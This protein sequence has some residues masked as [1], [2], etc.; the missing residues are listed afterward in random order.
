MIKT[1]LVNTGSNVVLMI[2]K[3]VVTLIMTPI[4]LSS[5]GSYD[6][7]LWGMI[8][9]IVGYMGL[10]DIGIRPS[11]SRFSA[12]YKA[13]NDTQNLNTV[14]VSTFLF[15]SVLGLF[16]C[17]CFVGWALIFPEVLSASD[18]REDAYVLFLLIIGGQL[19]VSFPGYVLESYL[20]GFQQ[21][22]VKNNVT[23]LVTITGAVF[24]FNFI[25]PE[26][27]LYLMA[28][29]A[30]VGVW[31]RFFV[32]WI[33]LF[34]PSSTGLRFLVSNYSFSKLKEVLVFGLKSFVQG[35]S[36]RVETSSDTLI[37]GFVLGPQAVPFYH[38]PASLAGYMRGIGWTMTHAFMPMFSN[39][40]ALDETSRMQELYLRASKYVVA[41][42]A[43]MA[44]GICFL[45]GEFLTIWLSPEFKE[46]GEYILY[47]AVLF[48]A[49]PF[50][51]PFSSRYLTGIGKHGYL[52]K[53]APFGAVLNISLSLLL[54]DHYGALGVAV[55]SV[56]T[57]SIFTPLYIRYVCNQMGHSYW[58]YFRFSVVP[59]FLPSLA[60]IA[61]MVGGAKI[62][63]LN[64]YVALLANAVLGGI[65]WFTV[66]YLCTLDQNERAAFKSLLRRKIRG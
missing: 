16:L 44:L 33:L 57:A 27:G 9:G 51:A 12:K 5:L 18:I 7:G 34:K 47:C 56:I 26:N 23:M 41:I 64:S 65:A 42:I 43:A 35:I 36:G 38:I 58:L 8:G 50:L 60:L 37:I 10:L 2:N 17:L 4:Y 46:K 31:L 32:Y 28:L 52:A 48:V 59:A 53:L 11:I 1:L 24:I 49:I 39:L 62:I 21:Y 14:F 19:L 13:L 6:Y 29:T 30:A 15:M 45:G 61:A 3:I 25:T 54:V 40:H 20:E 22:F 66:F 55:A 63:L